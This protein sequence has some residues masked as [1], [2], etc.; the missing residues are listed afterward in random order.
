MRIV[1]SLSA[2]ALRQLIGGAARVAGM[3]VAKETTDAVVTF[4]VRRFTDHSQRLTLALQIAN[5]RAWQAV[6]LGLGGNTVWERCQALLTPKEVQAFRTQAQA[7]LDGTPLN[8]RG[9]EF[10]KQCLRQLRLARKAGLLTEGALEPQALAERAGAFARFADPAAL[11]AAEF[12]VIDE[13]ADRLRDSG[14]DALAAVIAHRPE[15]G[16]PLL[17]AA[18]RYFFRRQLEEDRELFQGIVSGQLE[19]LEAHQEAGFTALGGLLTQHG[20]RLEE[21]LGDVQAVIAQTHGD[22]LDIKGELQRQGAQLQQLGQAVLLALDQYRLPP[23]ALRP[24]DSLSI[25]GT[26]DRQRVRALVGQFRAL[27]LAE[28]RQLPALQNGLGMLEVAAGEFAEAERDFREAASVLEDPAA[29]AAARHNAFQAAVEQRQWNE[30]LDAYLEAAA[31]LPERFALFPSAKYEAQRVLGAGG[32]GVVFQCRHRNSG[33]RVVVKALR[34]DTL[35]RALTDL[36]REAQVLEELDHPAIV[37]CRDCDFADA[38]RG[39]PFLVMDY[40]DGT[41]LGELVLRDGPLPSDALLPLARVMA[42]ALQ[43][44][45]VRSILHRDIKPANVL[46]RRDGAAWRVKLI[47]FGLALKQQVL[48]GALPAKTV[49]GSSVAGTRDYAAPEQMGQLPGVSVTPRSDLY[50]FGKTCCFALFRT[51]QPQRK[52]W[53]AVP[54]ALADLLEQCMAEAPTERPADFAEVLTRLEA[55]KPATVGPAVPAAITPAAAKEPAA[56]AGV[57]P[58]GPAASA[59]A[60]AH[61]PAKIPTAGT[62]SPTAVHAPAASA[63]PSPHDLRTFTGHTGPITAVAFAPDGRL[64]VSAAENVRVWE[65]ATGKELRRLAGHTQAVVALAFTPDGRE[66]LSASADTSVRI[67]DSATGKQLQSFPNWV[68]RCA[69]FSADGRRVLSG[70]AYDG[71]VRLFDLEVGRE[72]R[73]F[74]GHATFVRCLAFSPDGRR[75]LSGAGE[76]REEKGKGWALDCTLRCW[77][78]ET[79]REL[80]CLTGHTQPVCA[81]AFAPDGRTLFSGGQDNTLRAWDHGSGKQAAQVLPGPDQPFLT[82]A[83]DGRRVLYATAGHVY[84]W[85][86]GTPQAVCLERT[87]AVTALTFSPDGKLLLSGGA[88]DCAL[89]LWR[90]P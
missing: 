52:H 61:E 4:C 30:A 40:F 56:A 74:K 48:Q 85:E 84:V 72:V 28:R 78:A 27:P 36:F 10:R 35:D 26:G 20:D 57:G 82:P 16:A 63:P 54:E 89:R 7:F 1:Q 39:R 80:R 53:R 42:E 23:R 11:L 45:H 5:A 33:S 44:A 3:M 8:E 41:T 24:G 79:G 69:A 21:L 65:V 67:W 13:M 17:A 77:D 32:F 86:V 58:A 68:Q 38:Q 15:R 75:V 25:V 73:R 2:L 50:G 66:I 76:M 62:A 88:D 31:L 22:V 34:P 9:P 43:A 64:A 6:E 70:N 51:V 12:A 49:T 81:V 59:P 19:T 47:D 46:V 18:T 71:M 14:C 29:R 83:P 60:E 37:R 90:L 87:H 55:I